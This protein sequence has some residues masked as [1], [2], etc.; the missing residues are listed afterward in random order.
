[1]KDGGVY[2]SSKGPFTFLKAFVHIYDKV[3]S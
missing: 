2:V 3:A 1:M